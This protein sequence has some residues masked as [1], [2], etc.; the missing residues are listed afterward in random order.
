MGKTAT[1]NMPEIM[2]VAAAALELKTNVMAVY[3]WLDSGDL[4]RY[5]SVAGKI[6]L[7]TAESVQRLKQAREAT[8]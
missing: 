5:E 3:R 1:Q 8:S 7:V 4:D 2:T 6:T